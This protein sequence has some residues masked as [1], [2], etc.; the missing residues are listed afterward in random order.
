VR[1]AK[2]TFN[3]E[4]WMESRE[5]VAISQAFGL[6]QFWHARKHAANW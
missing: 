4:S 6:D 5:A 3:G 2:Q 1:I